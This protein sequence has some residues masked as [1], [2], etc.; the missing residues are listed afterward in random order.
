MPFLDYKIHRS[1]S[2]KIPPLKKF[3]NGIRRISR[4]VRSYKIADLQG[5]L[6]A[7]K[8]TLELEK[9]QLTKNHR[10]G[11]IS[12]LPTTDVTSSIDEKALS[13]IE[14]KTNLILD[15]IIKQSNEIDSLKK[16]VRSLRINR[17]RNRKE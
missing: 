7:H 1:K 5:V 3:Q 6:M 17:H 2:Y 14:F 12:T 9:I 10:F 15:Y 4:I 16:E 11:M 13:G 8:K